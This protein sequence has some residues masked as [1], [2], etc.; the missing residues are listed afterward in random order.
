MIRRES[1]EVT[2]D[3][4]ENEVED[5]GKS[6]HIQRGTELVDIIPSSSKA[7]QRR[8]TRRD[9][10]GNKIPSTC[11]HKR[12]Y[13][14]CVKCGGSNICVHRRQRSK[15]YECGGSSLCEHRREKNQ[16]VWIYL[17]KNLLLPH[18]QAFY[19]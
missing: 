7:H 12:H 11:E 13:T 14:Q 10:F 15:C 4:A 5:A 17:E 8:P 6:N 18:N 3:K 19:R 2:N 1:V 16:V 9:E